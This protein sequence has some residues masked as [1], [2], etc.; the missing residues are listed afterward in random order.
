MDE[1]DFQVEPARKKLKC[2]PCSTYDLP[3][4]VERR[5]KAS[6]CKT[7]KHRACKERHDA[8][9]AR[10]PLR[11]LPVNDLSDLSDDDRA[12]AVMDF[13]GSDLGEEFSIPMPMDLREEGQFWQEASRPDE[14]NDLAQHIAE[15]IEQVNEG[16]DAM[17]RAAMDGV[18]ALAQDEPSGWFPFN[19]KATLLGAIFWMS[20]RHAIS[21]TVLS[22]ALSL[23]TSFG[24][25]APSMYACE[26]D[27]KQARAAFKTQPERHVSPTNEPFYS[28]R[29]AELLAQNQDTRTS[30]PMAV[31]GDFHVWT[32]EIWLLLDGTIV[33]PYTFFEDDQGAMWAEGNVV[34]RSEGDTELHVIDDRRSFKLSEL[35]T[36]TA[37]TQA[38]RRLPIFDD[39]G[40]LRHT[41][42]LKVQFEG[43]KVFSVPVA[44]FTDD[45]SG[46]RSKRWNKHEAVT[47]ISATDQ[48]SQVVDELIEICENP[49]VVYD[50]QLK[51]EVVIRPF[52]LAVFCDNP[53]AAEMTASIG[54]NGLQF[55]RL[56]D[57]TV[58]GADTA[59]GFEQYLSP[60]EPRTTDQTLTTLRDLLDKAATGVKARVDELRKESGVKDGRCEAGITKLLEV[61]RIGS[62]AVIDQLKQTILTGEWHGPLFK[63][64]DLYGFEVSKC[65]PVEVLHT[66]LLG[67]AKYLWITTCAGT[68]AKRKA[69]GL[70]I[71]AA[72][73]SGIADTKNLNGSYLVSNAGSL[74]GKDV[75]FIAQVAAVTF[76]PL[77]EDGTI[78]SKVWEAWRWAAT[79]ML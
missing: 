49:F 63:L 28:R 68:E 5:H 36:N 3:T 34:Q 7:R 22:L 46:N 40:E 72:P 58:V 56:C 45:L 1:D 32:E 71:S 44:L 20:P 65:T 69:I 66:W 53:M 19:S 75:K 33:R 62:P 79:I 31:H 2:L 9:P 61:A 74:V 23:A 76:L 47:T 6:H 67:P 4:F 64:H 78:T 30:P 57:A 8:A 55:C 25:N 38:L 42:P 29:I 41:N 35:D 21:K 48:I 37:Q 70:R 50:C 16:L 17:L 73:T 59:D 15:E 54:L 26:R 27:L 77:V 39:Y 60:G 14:D 12:G 43:K 10:Q 52:L 18:Q 24:G 11:L 13:G 51:E